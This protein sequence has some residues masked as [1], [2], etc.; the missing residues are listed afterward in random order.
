M[1]QESLNVCLP[2]AV[3]WKVKLQPDK[4]IIRI[5][6]IAGSNTELCIEKTKHSVPVFHF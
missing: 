2:Y 5:I 1:L 6:R 3:V 4:I